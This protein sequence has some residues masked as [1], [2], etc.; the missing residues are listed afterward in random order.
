MIWEKERIEE[1]KRIRKGVGE[2]V[3]RVVEEVGDGRWVA[4]EDED[5]GMWEGMVGG[6]GKQ[7][8]EQLG[9]EEEK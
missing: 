1:W 8:N 4:P 6:V 2:E 7:F 5:G 9:Y 3:R